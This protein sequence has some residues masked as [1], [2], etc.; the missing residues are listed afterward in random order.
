MDAK[1]FVVLALVLTA[2]CLSDGECAQRPRR[3]QALGSGLGAGPR[4]F[5]PS[6]SRPERAQL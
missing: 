1:V 3:G 4:L 6:P 5:C 2:L